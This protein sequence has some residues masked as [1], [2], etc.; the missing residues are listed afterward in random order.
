[1]MNVLNIVNV[2]SSNVYNVDYINS[3]LSDSIKALE[4]EY[5]KYH[6]L[7]TIHDEG[8][9]VIV[10]DLHGDL[11]SLKHIM[12][13]IDKLSNYSLVFLGDYIDRGE[14]QVET[15]LIPLLMKLRYPDK[16]FLLRGNHEPPDFL[17]VY[18]HD[19]PIEL[20]H[21]YG[22][23]HGLRMYELFKELFQLLPHSLIIKDTALLLHG[24]PPTQNINSVE[25][26]HDYL[27]GRGVADYVKILEE[28]LWN[29]PAEDIQ[30]Y[31][32]SY[33]GAG[34]LFGPRITEKALN[35]TNTKVI[36]RGHEPCVNGFKLNHDNRVVTIFSRLGPP[37]YNEYA[38]FMVL[39]V[40]EGQQMSIEDSIIRFSL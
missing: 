27:I 28:V 16:V 32:P 17:P 7:I 3:I 23:E 38:S 40:C 4:Y 25:N 5:S 34:Y 35:I 19:F 8:T 6:G 33:R 39:K 11:R 2:V 14:N 18:P 31:E 9:Y 20:I 37:Y 29:D 13:F 15:I 10:G 24:G 1:M 26:V 30:Y 12:E 36:V 22:R 21:R